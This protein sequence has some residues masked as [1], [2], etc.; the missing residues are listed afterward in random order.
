VALTNSIYTDYPV[1]RAALKRQSISTCRW[2]HGGAVVTTYGTGSLIPGY[3]L[4]RVVR[5]A[6]VWVAGKTE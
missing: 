2:F 5:I 4:D 1:W 3:W 6:R